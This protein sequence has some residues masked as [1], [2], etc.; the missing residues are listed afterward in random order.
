[1]AVDV[2]AKHASELIHRPSPG[3]GENHAS[4]LYSLLFAQEE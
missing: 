4:E 3:V 2:G 1:M